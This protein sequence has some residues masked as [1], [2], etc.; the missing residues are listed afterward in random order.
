MFVVVE[1][2]F[3]SMGGILSFANEDI[4]AAVN[5]R[6]LWD[7]D[8]IRTL[9]SQL[10]TFFSKIEGVTERKVK[11]LNAI[12]PTT[13]LE[14]LPW[15][16]E[17]SKEWKQLGTFLCDSTVFE[18]LFSSSSKFDMVLNFFSTFI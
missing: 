2:L 7:K 8:T 3:V 12:F 13:Q 16:L 6:Y 10:A 9:H 18:K 4:A 17:K 5:S 14:E 15:Q 11:F 1:D